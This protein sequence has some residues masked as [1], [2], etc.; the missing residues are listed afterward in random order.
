M[1]LFNIPYSSTLR[2]VVLKGSIRIILIFRT[3]TFLHLPNIS[4]TKNKQT[5]KKPPNCSYYF[6]LILFTMVL[7]WTNQKQSPAIHKGR[8]VDSSCIRE[9]TVWI[10][11]QYILPVFLI[12][13]VH[14]HGVFYL[15]DFQRYKKMC[16]SKSVKINHFIAE[17]SNK[18]VLS[19]Q[20][21][22]LRAFYNEQSRSWPVWGPFK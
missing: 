10:H 13:I 3:G 20:F 14:L 21:S 22:V 18:I 4:Y 5:N 2:G 19:L 8:G 11:I 6:E 15:H 7:P 12:V 16:F 9:L 1:R 17:I